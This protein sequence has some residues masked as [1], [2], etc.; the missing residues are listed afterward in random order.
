SREL[1]Q[2]RVG[3][4]TFVKIKPLQRRHYVDI[5]QLSVS[6]ITA[7]QSDSRYIAEEMLADQISQPSRSARLPIRLRLIV[8]RYGPS[9]SKDRSRG[10][11]FLVLLLDPFSQQARNDRRNNNEDK[12]R[13]QTELKPA[14]SPR[15]PIRRALIRV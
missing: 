10:V 9:Q 11:A 4:S 14:P 12:Q 13:T 7:A 1:S 3:N 6:D 5:F 2:T 15:W 8:E